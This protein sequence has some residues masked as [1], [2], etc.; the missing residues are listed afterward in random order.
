MLLRGQLMPIFF[1]K[2]K[3]KKNYTHL[4]THA[5]ARTVNALLHILCIARSHLFVKKL[6][7]ELGARRHLGSESSQ[8][9][10]PGTLSVVNNA[11]NVL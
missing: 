9:G 6:L 7:R 1:A 8:A 11:Q 3:K 10:L 4:E 5:I 2:K